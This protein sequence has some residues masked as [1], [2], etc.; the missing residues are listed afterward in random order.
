MKNAK[1]FA[2]GV[3]LVASIGVIT[4]FNVNQYDEGEFAMNTLQGLAGACAVFLAKWIA[5]E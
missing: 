3:L 2:V 5:T 1:L 4:W